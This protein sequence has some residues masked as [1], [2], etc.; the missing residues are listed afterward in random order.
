MLAGS[1]ATT[2]GRYHSSPSDSYRSITDRVKVLQDRNLRQ[3]SCPAGIHYS[4]LMV[5]H[6][7]VG[8]RSALDSLTPISRVIQLQAMCCT[9]PAKGLQRIAI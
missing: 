8:L 2:A 1:L 9:L 6:Q 3:S 4:N 7:A 5:L